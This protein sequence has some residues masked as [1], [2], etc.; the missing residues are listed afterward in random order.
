MSFPPSPAADIDWTTLDLTVRDLGNGHIES[1]Y[2]PQTGVWS[3]PKLIKDP[4]LRV[5]GLAPALNYGQ[6]AFEGLKAHRSPSDEI[7]LFRPGKHAARMQH[8]TSVVSIPEIPEEHFLLCVRLVV[9][10]NAAFIPPN[11]SG[12]A[13][14]IRPVVF[15]SSGHLGLNPPTE[16]IFCVYIHPFSSYH[17]A[18]PIDAL[19]LEEFDRAAPH[20]TGNAKLGG[21]YAPVMR[22]AAKARSEGFPITLHLDSQT[23]SQIDEFSTSGFLGIRT[24]ADGAI[25]LVLPDSDNV[26]KSITS[27]SCVAIAKSL[28]WTVEMRPIPYE[29]LPLFSEILAAGTAAALVPIRS[30]TCRSRAQT[31]TYPA[32]GPAGGVCFQQLYDRLKG[33]QAGR[34]PDPYGW[35]DKVTA[36]GAYVPDLGAVVS[37]IHVAKAEPKAKGAATQTQLFKPS[38]VVSLPSLLMVGLPWVRETVASLWA[39]G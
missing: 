17:G 10:L 28:G 16:Y 13:L 18:A 25:T 27:D 39:F 30:I 4:Y 26:I 31:F 19:I 9:S 23:R 20:G 14:Y 8:S 29:S 36:A 38:Y 37:E 1:R 2:S 3:A 5:H 32:T 21:N 34:L 12:G 7:L 22:W 33:I 24:A 6:Q 11:S 35:C 15:G